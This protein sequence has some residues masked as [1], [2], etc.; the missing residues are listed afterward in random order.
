MVGSR[1][2]TLALSPARVA[3]T[4]R[5]AMVVITGGALA[6][7][8]LMAPASSHPP[9]QALAWL[10]F[11]GS[12]TH[13]AATGWFSTVPSFRRQA[14]RHRDR[15]V[16][17]PVVTVALCGGLAAVLS[18]SVMAWV[19]LV[20]F[21]WQFHHFQKQNLGLVALGAT[22][23]G[24]T[25]LKRSE[26]HAVM[27]VGWCGIGALLARPGLLQLHVAPVGGDLFP[28]AAS[29]YALAA[30]AG[31]VLLVRRQRVERPL[32]F[33]AMYLTTLVFPLPIFLFRS[34]Y[35]AVAG[36]TIAHGLQYLALVGLVALGAEPGGRRTRSTVL[37]CCV[38]LAGGTLL[39][40][41]SHLHN[42]TPSLRILFGVYLG[43][44]SSHFIVDAGIWL[45]RDAFSRGFLTGRVPFLFPE[46]GHGPVNRLPID[47]LPI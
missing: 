10:L 44:A 17:A 29:G 33:C 34:P 25:G 16:I 46:A 27:A 24:V 13:V 2:G 4:W 19:L 31:L 28:T 26:R 11:L 7:G 21:A 36:M 37:L 8:V 35:A 22:S 18:P 41:L 14:R 9:A 45:L 30:T 12:S 15:Y 38:A 1:A 5:W 32:G 43:L 3:A 23:A 40:V 47:R 20:F 39:S 6:L 42:A